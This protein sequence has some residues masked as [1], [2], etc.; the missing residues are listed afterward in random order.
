MTP[1]APLGPNRGH[2]A[3]RG[4]PG[5]SRGPL[6]QRIGG[7]MLQEAPRVQGNPMAGYAQGPGLPR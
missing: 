2:L 7:Q 6:E 4:P 3:A 5:G 1:R